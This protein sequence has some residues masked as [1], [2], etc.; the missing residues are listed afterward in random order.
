MQD[1]LDLATRAAAALGTAMAGIDLLEG[2][3]GKTFIVEANAVPGWR[4]LETVVDENIA[5]VV[6]AELEKA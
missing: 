3:G 6:I 2:P 4:G 1:W 5:D